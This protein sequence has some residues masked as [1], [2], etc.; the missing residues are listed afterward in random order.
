MHFVA[1]VTA[2]IGGEMGRLLSVDDAV[3]HERIER[4]EPAAFDDFVVRVSVAVSD[5]AL[6]VGPDSG[7]VGVV[8]ATPDGVGIEEPEGRRIGSGGEIDEQVWLQPAE[9]ADEVKR[10]VEVATERTSLD[11]L[12]DVSGAIELELIDAIFGDHLRRC[13]MK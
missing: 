5:P 9:V 7:K 10:R 12:I 6:A 13:F 1:E 11:H 2:G 8:A 4:E 3:Q